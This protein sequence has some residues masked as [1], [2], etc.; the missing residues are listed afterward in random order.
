MFSLIRFTPPRHAIRR[1]KKSLLQRSATK[2]AVAAPIVSAAVVVTDNG[3][4]APHVHAAH[5]GL[6]TT[7][8]DQL[9]VELWSAVRQLAAT[10]TTTAPTTTTTAGPWGQMIAA[11]TRA[12]HATGPAPARPAAAPARPA[13]PP[14]PPVV[15]A[16]RGPHTARTIPL[17]VFTAG[18]YSSGAASFAAQTGTHPQLLS[19]YL[20]GVNGWSAMDGAAG[21]GGW[22]ASGNRLVIG[23]PIIPGG[24]GGTLAAGASGAYNAYFVTLAQNLVSAGAGDSILRLGWEFNGGWYLWSV[25]NTTD[26]ADFAAYFRNIVDAMRSVPGQSFQF[27]WNPNGDGPT[28]YPP[29]QAYPGSAYVDFIGS[30][31]YDNCW[32]SAMTPQNA[33]DA[34]LTQPW[35]LDWLASFSA[36]VGRPI[37]FPEWGLSRRSDGHG[38]GD[39]PY[40]VDQFAA[41]ITQSDV[42]WT[43]YFNADPSGQSDAITDG[44]FPLALAAF[45]RDFG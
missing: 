32:C 24:T 16:A 44:S 27:V 9:R 4:L 29:A 13:A 38:M 43:S 42:A 40:F 2:V 45:V 25:H 6:R 1:V 26:A 5:A 11:A 10:T 18:G 12:P 7:S 15:F 28:A 20:N 19:E 34:Q 33:W 3:E 21:A 17:G 36:Q 35:G 30:D 8:A 22:R 14:A 23:V 39:D 31:V 37:A 41:W